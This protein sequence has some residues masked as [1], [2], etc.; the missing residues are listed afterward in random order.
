MRYIGCKAKLLD[1]ID[2]AINS[3]CP[4][5]KTACD[6]FS[7]TATVARN[8]KKR[9]E[10]TSNDLL[11][12]SY[13][14]QVATIE[15]DKEPTFKKL[16]DA[17]HGNPLKFF[18]EMDT[19]SMENLP[20]EKRIFQNN[21]S[22]I[23]NRMYFTEENAL[24]IDYARNKIEE[25]KKQDLLSQHEYYYLLACV[26]EGI[27]FVSNTSGTYGAFNKFWDKRSFKTFE[28]FHLPVN[29]NNLHNR[30][31]NTDG[32]ELLKSIA[33]DVLYVDPP[34]NARQYLPNYHILETAA[35]YDYPEI[36]GIT[37]QRPSN[38]CKSEFCQKRKVLPAFEKLIA[39][40]NYKHIILSY[41]TEGLMAINDIRTIM[42]HYGKPN[43]FDIIEIPYRRFKSRNT[44]HNGEIKELL[45]HIEKE[46]QQ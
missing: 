25:W 38:E 29:T 26:I 6:I 9:F 16:L 42:Q 7:G 33:G 31:Y 30:C 46:T 3:Y 14:L 34:Y 40:A 24:R 1:Y 39:N 12:F 22:P 11:Y 18:N 13:V 28:L 23:G 35:K 36:K 4:D 43:T 20:I 44:T 17:G 10:V 19:S 8:L 45:I 21:Y 15:N 27:P 37:G 5:A 41:N 2:N 32:V